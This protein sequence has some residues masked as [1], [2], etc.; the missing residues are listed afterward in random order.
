MPK[1]G[2]SVESPNNYIQICVIHFRQ[3]CYTND[4]LSTFFL[5]SPLIIGT[6]NRGE[7]DNVY[8]SKLLSG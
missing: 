8:T 2:G 6:I 3:S 4:R 7:G 5:L 1:E